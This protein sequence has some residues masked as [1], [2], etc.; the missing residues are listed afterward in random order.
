MK[1][2]R[3]A[4]GARP[5]WGRVAGYGGAGLLV[6][7]AVAVLLMPLFDKDPVG[8]GPAAGAGPAQ[9]TG[10]GTVPGQGGGVPTTPGNPVPQQNNGGRPYPGGRTPQQNQQGGNPNIGPQYPA[11]GG[12]ALTWC[13]EGT[14]VYRAVQGGVDL[15]I[16]VTASGLVRA[17]MT[18]G[19]RE[20][21]VRQ[22]TVKAGRP[23]TFRFQG[24]SPAL[25][26]RVKITTVSIGAAM[27]TCYARPAS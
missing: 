3:G 8:G 19:G 20:P 9:G 6:V 22:A 15:L 21:E 18:L 14:A 26:Q 2:T 1:S 16:S 12:T 7:I 27:E 24:I 10:P 5:I 4:R 17:E 25:V 13:P 23:H 11:P